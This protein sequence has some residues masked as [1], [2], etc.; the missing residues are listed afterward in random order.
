MLVQQ[1]YSK[2]NIMRTS[3]A[4]VSLVILFGFCGT[5]LRAGGDPVAAPENTEWKLKKET[6]YHDMSYVEKRHKDKDFGKFIKS[7]KKDLKRRK[8][9]H[10]TTHANESPAMTFCF[11]TGN[12]K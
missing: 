7:A 10:E 11:R 1:A 9:K 12:M 2:P 3:I 8:S 5:V 6:E 4:I